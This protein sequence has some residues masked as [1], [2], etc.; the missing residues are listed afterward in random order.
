MNKI[1]RVVIL[2]NFFMFRKYRFC[3][4][5]STLELTAAHRKLFIQIANSTILKTCDGRTYQK[6]IKIQER[7][8]IFK[9]LHEELD[10]YEQ[11]F[12]ERFE[13]DA[14]ETNT[15][16]DY[17]QMYDRIMND[18]VDMKD[19]MQN[20][21]AIGN[22]LL[23]DVIDFYK[24]VLNKDHHLDTDE[25]QIEITPG[26]GGQEAQLFCRDLWN[27]YEH[28]CKLKNF[29]WKSIRGEIEE[30]KENSTK[31]MMAVVRGEQVYEHFIQENGIHR[32]QRVPVNSKKIHTST[33]I[34]FVFDEKSVTNKILKKIK[35]EKQD[36]LFETKRSGGAGGQSVNKNETCVKVTHKPT[37]ISVEMQKTSSQIQ[38]KSMAIQALKNKLYNFYYEYEKE[39]F[40]K[41]KKSHKMNGDRS[42]KIRTYNF[43]HN[44]VMDHITNT[45]YPHIDQFFKGDQ[46]LQ[47]MYRH[48]QNFYQRIVDEAFASILSHTTL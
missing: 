4:S 26:V 3:S 32:V 27:M 28:L 5:L 34:V 47:L 1:C 13:I 23:L 25:V 20:I 46:L 33:S 38:N 21:H 40:I 31:G 37:N 41:N 10:V 35:L 29:E 24:T 2:P 17:K 7:S 16:I 8:K 36:L 48:R 43:V 14:K 44:F 22:L 6:I 9:S 19:L 42:Q 11:L 15:T 30:G 18:D 45:H 39:Q 12:Q